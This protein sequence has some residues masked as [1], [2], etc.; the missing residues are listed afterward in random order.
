M[1]THH[2]LN[3]DTLHL[4]A[5]CVNVL[6]ANISLPLSCILYP[7]HMQTL[8]PKILQQGITGLPVSENNR[9][10]VSLNTERVKVEHRHG[11]GKPLG[12][13]AGKVAILKCCRVTR[14]SY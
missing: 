10:V 8:W 3:P 12:V 1:L 11:T 7:Q 5:V 13:V 4:Q 9:P 6:L 2:N 14:A